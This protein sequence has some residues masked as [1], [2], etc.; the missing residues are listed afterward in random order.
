MKRT[1]WIRWLRRHGLVPMLLVTAGVLVFTAS[2]LHAAADDAGWEL[3]DLEGDR[4][5]LEGI[6]IRGELLDAY[7]RTSFRVTADGVAHE[8]EL[9]EAYR[10]EP[11]Y[12]PGRIIGDELWRVW[13]FEDQT[14]IEKQPLDRPNQREQV[15]ISGSY[16]A[17]DARGNGRYGNQVEYGL[18]SAEGRMYYV[19]PTSI[20]YSGIHAI[21][22]LR[23]DDEMKAAEKLVELDMR[24]N[25]GERSRGL[26]VLGLEAA[27]DKLV[28]IMTEDRDRLIVRCYDSRT[29]ELLGETAARDFQAGRHSPSYIASADPD[30]QTISLAFP[31]GEEL[32]AGQ[33]A[34]TFL[35]FSLT[36][37][38]ISLIEEVQPVFADG[39]WETWISRM[40]LGH[41]GDKL[42]AA[43][44]VRAAMEH[45]A[46]YANYYVGST[47]FMIYV[48][49]DGE[50]TYRGE[51]ITDQ[52]D[53]FIYTRNRPLNAGYSPIAHREYERLGIGTVGR[54]G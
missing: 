30:G 4:R 50:L 26:E 1:G 47:R 21:Y 27:G 31:R 8:T 5:A 16:G 6:V 39:S 51:L 33:S 23:F 49:E 11:R 38:G 3:M 40:A 12:I 48:F 41:T 2:N 13:N 46:P 35:S 42:V 17:L 15:I 20:Y 52:N 7:H 25:D 43:M 28:L 36:D 34:F 54:D 10:D 22:R 19:T 44:T 37:D 24:G 29:G 32:E 53:D 45:D 9:F 14:M 18:A